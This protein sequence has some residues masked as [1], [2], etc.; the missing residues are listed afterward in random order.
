MASTTRE[1]GG[2]K[3]DSGGSY[4]FVVTYT[5]KNPSTG[6]TGQWIV[7]QSEPT[8]PPDIID[9]TNPASL[10]RYLR[11]LE[12]TATQLGNYLTRSLDS[13]AAAQRSLDAAL[14]SGD[15]QAA[16]R[17]RVSLNYFNNEVT[18][19]RQNLAAAQGTGNELQNN[20]AAALAAL[21]PPVQEAVEPETPVAQQ[22]Q[23]AEQEQQNSLAVASSETAGDAVATE[24]APSTQNTGTNTLGGEPVTASEV[25]NIAELE[26]PGGIFSTTDISLPSKTTQKTVN[27]DDRTGITTSANTLKVSNAPPAPT[28]KPNP[29]LALS[30]YTYGISLHILGEDDYKTLLNSPQS[31]RVTKNIISSASRY[32]D[33]RRNE[34]KEDFYFDS[35]NMTTVM[36]LGANTQGTNAITLKFK[37]IEPYGLSFMNRLLDVSRALNIKNY[38]EQP[39]LLEVNFF[40]YDDA[41]NIKKD[42]GLTK[43][44]PIKILTMRIRASSRGS[45]YD[46]DAVPY[47]QLAHMESIQAVRANFEV[48]ASTVGD[49][50]SSQLAFGTSA[51]T[52]AVTQQVANDAQ[53]KESIAEIKSLKLNGAPSGLTYGSDE[54]ADRAFALQENIKNISQ[55]PT[56]SVSSFPGAYNLWLAQEQA[57]GYMKVADVIAFDIDSAIASATITIPAKTPPSRASTSDG[58]ANS[59]APATDTGNNP[60]TQKKTPKKGPDFT[61]L[62]KSINAGTSINSLINNV[63][64]NSSFIRDQLKGTESENQSVNSGQALFSAVA[65][66]TGKSSVKWFKIIPKIELLGYDTIRNKY[67]K[68]ITYYIRTYDHYNN[69]DPRVPKGMPPGAVKDYE[70]IYTGKNDSIIDFDIEFDSL[71]NILVN[72]SR[73]KTESLNTAGGANPNKVFT[74]LEENQPGNFSAPGITLTSNSQRSMTQGGYD[75]AENQ[76]AAGYAE[77]IY[78]TTGGQMVNVRLK[79]IGDPDFIKQDEFLFH[80]GVLGLGY[81][82]QYLPGAGNSLNMD[83]GEIYVNLK[84]KTPSDIDE[85]TGML[86]KDSAYST[87]YFSGLYKIMTIDNQFNQG[88]FTQVLDL[89]RVFNQPGDTKSTGSTSA[90]TGRPVG[91]NTASITPVTPNTISGPPSNADS[92]MQEGD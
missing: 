15:T 16:A 22:E 33:V 37:L 17:H 8:R 1:F 6:A 63:I 90:D 92:G 65:P 72:V 9:G 80:P 2:A 28:V 77:S 39:Y 64:I 81:N 13:A 91:Q 87:S 41:G 23:Q 71:Y 21:A 59:S 27:S 43:W 47:G 45:E 31:F 10:S 38:V 58:T 88:K 35:L 79:I 24:S 73:S 61:K 84:F 66:S 36:G 75:I 86:R 76:L 69:V 70:Y 11:F 82:A 68:K 83:S 30:S 55:A 46:I 89:V 40:G 18:A 51:V 62:V 29:L 20:S 52:Q 3:S 78:S 34:F 49:Y 25:D 74:K 19:T 14:Q 4:N 60:D 57:H 7:V 48:T 26:E 44:V 12:S 54:D 85:S 67:A 50:F 42:P 5:D 53:R 32:S 56:L